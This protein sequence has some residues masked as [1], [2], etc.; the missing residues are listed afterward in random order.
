MSEVDP[1]IQNKWWNNPF[2]RDIAYSAA[3]Y[4]AT[5]ALT[6]LATK[7]V[8]TVDQSKEL[9]DNLTE[10]IVLFA[11]AAS[12]FA[13]VVAKIAKRRAE[14][15]TALMIAKMTENEIKVMVKDP[16]IETPTVRTPPSTIPGV[17]K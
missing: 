15:M 17:P 10:K 9:L 3:K 2:Y 13:L 12:P 14:Y 6:T 16:L 8:I 7:H 11:I 5:M 1:Q 4:V